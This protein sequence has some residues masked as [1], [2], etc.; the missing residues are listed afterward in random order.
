[1]AT[2]PWFKFYGGEYLADPK[3]ASLTPQERSCW[4]TLLCL[5]GM[6]SEPGK[7]EFLTIDALLQKSGV[8]WDPYDTTEWDSARTVLDKLERMKMI[9]KSEDGVIEIRNWVKRQETNLTEAERAKS[10]RD[11][12]RHANVTD[13]V[14]NVT[15]EENR[16]DK[17]LPADAEGFTE[18][19]IGKDEPTKRPSASK[20]P[21]ALEVFRW[22][23]NPQKSWES[24]KNVQERE[25]AEFLFSRGE[26][27]VKK[28]LRYLEAHKDE[29]FL[30]KVTK[31]SDLEKKWEDI[32]A[33][34]KR[35]S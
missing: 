22:F 13:N 26:E 5:A 9:T 7:V 11:R 33:Y 3:I 32:K 29:E 30:P 17:I 14:T 28:A 21:H 8:I 2:N 35:N 12:K 4:I 34:A 20:Y 19:P 6:S 15:Q 16:G 1:M 18:I 23:P 25:Y 31:P 10:Y 27:D 24:M